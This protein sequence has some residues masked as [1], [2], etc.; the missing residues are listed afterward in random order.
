[1]QRTDVEEMNTAIPNYDQIIM[2]FKEL[3][4]SQY[5]R[6]F[7]SLRKYVFS[8]RSCLSCK[9]YQQVLRRVLFEILIE[10]YEE[11]D[12][13]SYHKFA[14]EERSAVLHQNWSRIINKELMRD[15]IRKEVLDREYYKALHGI[16]VRHSPEACHD[17]NEYIGQCIDVCWM[18]LMPNKPVKLEPMTWG[19]IEGQ[20]PLIFNQEYQLERG[21][22]SK[23]YKG[24]KIFYFV[25]PALV[26]TRYGSPLKNEKMEV[27]LGEKRCEPCRIIC[28]CIK[29]S[30]IWNYAVKPL[31]WTY[32]SLVVLTVVFFLVRVQDIVGRELL[33]ILTILT[34]F[35]F[36]RYF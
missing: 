30:G 18:M 10:C 28:N 5:E 35:V 25:W 1:M 14:K 36:V 3:R 7:E 9:N 13:S 2:K 11:C 23:G 21:K 27:V 31:L 26:I 8:R 6:T 20:S 12:R 19:P 24:S 17:L 33:L 29:R 15:H 34:T 4:N 32:H 16:S 22:A